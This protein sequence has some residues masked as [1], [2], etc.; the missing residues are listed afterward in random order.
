MVAYTLRVE[1]LLLKLRV[2]GK[3]NKVVLCNEGLFVF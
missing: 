1:T 3:T 2:T